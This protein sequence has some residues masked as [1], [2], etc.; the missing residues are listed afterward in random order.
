MSATTPPHDPADL[1]ARLAAAEE[2]V[3]KMT[4]RLDAEGAPRTDE[5]R[6]S[7]RRLKMLA[8]YAPVG[9]FQ[10]NAAGRCIFVNDRW[11]ELTGIGPEQAQGQGW[12]S[13]LHPEDRDRILA[14]WNLSVETQL[15]FRAEHRFRRPDGSITWVLCEAMPDF[16]EKGAFTGFIG[17]YTDLTWLQRSDEDR[18]SER[19]YHVLTRAAPV[20]VFQTDAEG[21]CIFA[22]EQWCQMSGLSPEEAR[23]EGWLDAVHVEDR[24]RVT[25]EWTLALETQ[26][27]FRAE[28]RF[29]RPDGSV[30]WVSSQAM[31][32]FEESG[33]FAGFVGT[34]T[35]VT[36]SRRA[37]EASA[38]YAELGNRLNQA[39]TP[40]AAAQIT[41]DVA[42]RLLGMDAGALHLVSLERNQA[43]V[44]LTL[45]TIDGQ[46]AE[47]PGDESVTPPTAMM[48]Q[49][50]SAGAQLILRT[51]L[52]D[53]G[54][55]LVPP[56]PGGRRPAS[57]MFV[58]IRKQARMVGMLSV[59]SY[60]SL[61][62][63]EENLQTLQG[64]ADYV[65][66]ALDRI[67]AAESLRRSQE[68]KFRDLVENTTD[69]VQSL[70]PDGSF[71]FVNRAWLQTLGYAEGDVPCLKIFDVVHPDHRDDYR[72]MFDRI[73]RGEALAHM[74]TVFVARDGRKVHIEGNA[75]CRFE[76][77][78]PVASRGIFRD[79]TQR[80]LAEQERERIIT[81]LQ[82]ALSQVKT[83]SGLLPMC[84][85]C[86]KIRDDGGYWGN[87][88]NY[89][90]KHS[91]VKI[92][93]G[94]CPDC[95]KKFAGELLPENP[96]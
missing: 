45:D 30:T 79:V 47:V 50:N 7:D 94:M 21:K 35:D 20:G 41:L 43:S 29:R 64:L 44:V 76:E 60:A 86:R 24:E 16:D 17:T 1:T 66:G 34:L 9:V 52:Y 51:P 42:W 82:E 54:L 90:K 84:A 38:A 70:A 68:E 32:D 48:R 80:L 62:Y 18:A 27:P 36:E 55:E 95:T 5:Q 93:H 11:S 83:L 31:P 37:V 63:S 92:S 19:R 10:T 49:V 69:L 26:L 56:G 46:R 8:V 3:R 25:A 96:K 28:H 81:E 61:A 12:F 23:S 77:G 33:S 85:W 53:P 14:Q 78:R 65:S 71:Q 15:P 39:T 2:K 59:Q 57:L 72:Q 67:E 6:A 87:V 74:S 13:T 91:D 22:N 88:E 40:L 4:T 89:L 58:P 75:S 73:F